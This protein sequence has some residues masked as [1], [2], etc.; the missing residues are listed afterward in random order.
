MLVL[1]SFGCISFIG[2]VFIYG[3]HVALKVNGRMVGLKV[4]I[5]KSLVVLVLDSLY[6]LCANVVSMS[7]MRTGVILFN[8]Q[9][10]LVS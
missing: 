4:T 5:G 2:S 9:P 10:S 3:L 8:V 1:G 7:V 6:F